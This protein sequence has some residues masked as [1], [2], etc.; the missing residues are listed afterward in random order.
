MVTPLNQKQA[1][2]NLQRYLRRISFE[3]EAESRVPVDGIFDEATRQALRDFQEESGLPVTGV[4]DKRTWDT[5]FARYSYLT[6]GQLTSQGL[7]L[8]PQEPPN[9]AVTLGDTLTLVRI[10]QI[11]LL[12]LRAVYEIFED[13]AESGTYDEQTMEAIRQF[14]IIHGLPATGEV[15]E[16]TWN[17]IV[18]EYSNLD[19]R[20]TV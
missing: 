4:A 19:A 5:L 14:Q 12:E 18:R 9:Y 3:S 16:L 7:Y 2:S 8:F 15:D 13:V 17:A 11:L 20:E 1:I 10:I 6:R